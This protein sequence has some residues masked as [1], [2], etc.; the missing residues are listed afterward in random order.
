VIKYWWRPIE[1]KYPKAYQKIYR[2]C[3]DHFDIGDP[4]I[5]GDMIAYLPSLRNLYDFFDENRIYVMIR[6]QQGEFDYQIY[7]QNNLHY[8]YGGVSKIRIGTERQAFKK[9]FEILESKLL[10]D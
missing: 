5:A 9:A 3:S 2:Y 1:E 4:N 10:G 6:R 7:D 8:E